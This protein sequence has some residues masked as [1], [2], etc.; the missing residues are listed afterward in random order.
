MDVSLIL[1]V[2]LHTWLKAICIFLL[3]KRLSTLL[4]FWGSKREFLI[5]ICQNFLWMEEF[6][7]CIM[8]HFPSM[9][10]FAV[11]WF[12]NFN[13][14]R[15]MNHFWGFGV[16]YLAL[17]FSTPILFLKISVFSLTFTI[18]LYFF[19][20]WYTE[21]YCGVNSD[22]KPVFSHPSSLPAI[23]WSLVPSPWIEQSTLSHCLEML[24]F[25]L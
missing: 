19:T 7:C 10:L 22:D 6:T 24:R 12:W 8:L 21:I 9:C 25:S 13:V 14:V 18:L 1:N 11:L 2:H 15:V 16:M 17:A 4:Y 5:L 3:A 20:S 23:V